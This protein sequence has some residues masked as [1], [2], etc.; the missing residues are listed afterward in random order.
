MLWVA[1]GYEI[2]LYAYT[3]IR[4]MNNDESSALA[5]YLVSCDHIPRG[6]MPLFR[7]KVMFDGMN[8]GLPMRSF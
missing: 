3:P 7:A 4:P 6:S 1:I 5:K 2:K 8:A